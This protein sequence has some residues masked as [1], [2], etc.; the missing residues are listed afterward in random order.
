M[1]HPL[2]GGVQHRL[3]RFDA[4]PADIGDPD[5]HSLTRRRYLLPPGDVKAGT[6]HPG[7][8]DESIPSVLKADGI[9]I[10]ELDLRVAVAAETSVID[11]AATPH[12]MR[13]LNVGEREGGLGVL[14]VCL[15]E[16]A[17]LPLEALKDL[18]AVHGQA[19][20][21]FWGEGAARCTEA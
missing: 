9:Q 5:A 8:F 15:E 14:G 1:G 20:T 17:V 18:V 21:E 19:F 2:T 6:K 12:Q 16:W 13:C 10:G 11:C 7:P 3:G 4:L